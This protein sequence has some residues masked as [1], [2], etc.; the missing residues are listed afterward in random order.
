MVD[1]TESGPA[2]CKNRV[3]TERTAIGWDP[4]EVWLTRIRPHQHPSETSTADSRTHEGAPLAGSRAASHIS[5]LAAA[6]R[7]AGKVRL[8]LGIQ[9]HRL[10]GD[11][12]REDMSPR[13]VLPAADGIFKLKNR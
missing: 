12:H 4:Y 10:R 11:P 9:L 13:R 5:P 1:E 6:A 7:I 8:L 3:T 2:A